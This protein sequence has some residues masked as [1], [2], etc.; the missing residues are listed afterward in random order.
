M[1][2]ATQASIRATQFDL[3]NRGKVS[4]GSVLGDE[5]LPIFLHNLV[6]RHLHISHNAPNLSTPPP[7]P[8]P[9]CI[10]FV[11]HFSW[12]LQLSQEKLKT[13][14]MQNFG[15]QIRCIMGKVEVAFSDKRVPIKS[16]SALWHNI[17][18]SLK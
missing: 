18:Q 14:L 16:H 12:I 11:F 3:A 15:E 6:K 17:D 7:P 2:C 5:F 8:P 13:M 1:T 9:F 10:T 4:C